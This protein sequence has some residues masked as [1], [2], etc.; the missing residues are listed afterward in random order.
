M[1]HSVS[2]VG[3]TIFSTED[4]TIQDGVELRSLG[5]T[6]INRKEP[7][8]DPSDIH[9]KQSV[10]RPLGGGKLQREWVAHFSENG[11]HTS[12]EYAQWMQRGCGI[13]MW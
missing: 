6:K 13:L 12:Q 7:I 8:L 4:R 2:L 9:F 3:S 10:S 1:V 11:W 5:C